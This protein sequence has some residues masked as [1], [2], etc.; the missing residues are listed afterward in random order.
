M[1]PVRRHRTAIALCASSLWLGVPG[2]AAAESYTVAQ[3]TLEVETPS[4]YC[5]LDRNRT[6]EDELFRVIEKVNAGLNRVLS[7][8]VDCNELAQWRQGAMATIER[9]GQ[10][11][12]PAQE[13]AYAGLPRRIFLEE[14][15]KVMGSAF[16]SGL[17]QGRDRMA[18]VL[19]KLKLGEVRSLGLLATDDLALYAGMA[20]LLA[21]TEGNRVI[22]GIVAM[23]LVNEVPVSVNLY[24]TYEGPES[25][26]ALLVEQQQFLRDLMA[27]N[28]TLESRQLPSGRAQAL[29]GG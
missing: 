1:I 23:T 12:T 21:S 16:A 19:P 3:R 15:E 14:L 24:R 8:F 13:I 10:V 5:R 6:A 11:L 28:G 7:V 25:I 22:A 18:A 9:Y 20:E 4:A 17:E 27:G 29:K 26:D 2:T